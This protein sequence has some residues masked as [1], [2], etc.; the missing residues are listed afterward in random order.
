M[1]WW[2][3]FI[4]FG[5]ALETTFVSISDRYD[6]FHILGE[7]FRF[8][9]IFN[10]FETFEKPSIFNSLVKTNKFVSI[11]KR[12]SDIIDFDHVYCKKIAI[13]NI[14]NLKI[15][16]N[17]DIGIKNLLTGNVDLYK[18]VDDPIEHDK[19]LFKFQI[20]QDGKALI[21]ISHQETLSENV[22]ILN[23]YNEIVS[24]SFSFNI[25]NENATSY[26]LRRVIILSWDRNEKLNIEFLYKE[27]VTNLKSFY[28]IN[29]DGNQI[30]IYFSQKDIERDKLYQI[31]LDENLFFT[32]DQ[33]GM[34]R[35]INIIMETCH[36]NLKEFFARITACKEGSIC[37]G[38]ENLRACMDLDPEKLF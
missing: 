11:M 15:Y 12:S 31:L 20:D 1:I 9:N 4:N 5:L 24:D 21:H 30:E 17:F 35:K 28:S 14:E 25:I 3:Y 34:K 37:K 32:N 2:L 22:A 10:I 27:L 18:I 6:K 7:D 36:N 23:F 19:S 38:V 16:R 29:S 13:P 26:F 33:R 8:S